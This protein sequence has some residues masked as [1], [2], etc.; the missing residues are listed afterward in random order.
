MRDI[1]TSIGF[2]KESEIKK[3]LFKKLFYEGVDL[4]KQE[5]ELLK[6]QIDKVTIMHNLNTQSINIRQYEDA[7]REYNAIQ[8]IEVRVNARDKVKKVA[9]MI[10]GAIPQPVVLQVKYKQEYMLALGLRTFDEK[11]K[12]KSKIEEW[13]FSKWINT[14]LLTEKENAFLQAINI[15]NLSY[16]HFYRF[17]MDIVEQVNRYNASLLTEHYVKEIDSEEVKALYYQVELY[18]TEISVLKSKLKKESQFNKKVEINV[19]IKRIQQRREELIQ[20]LNGGVKN[21]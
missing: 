11:N 18:D 2:P 3:T 14:E 20:A 19:K 7:T 15:K 1:I 10:I 16:T 9:E 4:S 8:V 13:T 21:E 12:D 5:K 17:Y 6:T